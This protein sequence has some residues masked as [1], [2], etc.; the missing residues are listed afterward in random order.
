MLAASCTGQANYVALPPPT[1][2]AQI[3]GRVVDSF[4]RYAYGN[5]LH[6]AKRRAEAR[7][8]LQ[9]ADRLG[10]PRAQELLGDL[11]ED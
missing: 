8:E 2:P 11:D 6:R 5:H 10:H 9:L 7:R 4:V 3:L 1:E